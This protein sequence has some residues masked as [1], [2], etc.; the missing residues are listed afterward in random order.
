MFLEYILNSKVE[1]LASLLQSSVSQGPS[2]F[3]L[4]CLFAAQE[5][6]LIIINV[7]NIFD[8]SYFCGNHF[9]GE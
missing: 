6:L 5:T 1:F 4:I 2:G 7:E 9:F 8:T 3:V